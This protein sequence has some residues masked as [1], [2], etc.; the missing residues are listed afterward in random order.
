MSSTFSP[1]DGL[2]TRAQIIEGKF[3]NMAQPEGRYESPID[4]TLDKVDVIRTAMPLRDYEF[5]NLL[6]ADKLLCT[7]QKCYPEIIDGVA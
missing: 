7:L 2:S 6:E 5:L 1:D 3:C 4:G